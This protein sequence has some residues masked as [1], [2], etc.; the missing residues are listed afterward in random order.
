VFRRLSA[1]TSERLAE[2]DTDVDSD[3]YPVIDAVADTQSVGFSEP[4]PVAHA[5]TDR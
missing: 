1:D 3:F 5:D 4:H 2:L